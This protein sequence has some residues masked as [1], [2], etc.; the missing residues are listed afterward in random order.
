MMDGLPDYAGFAVHRLAARPPIR[1]I[2]G[3]D[4]FGAGHRILS[5]CYAAERA[6][7]MVNTAATPAAGSRAAGAIDDLIAAISACFSRV[8][9]RPRQF[10]RLLLVVYGASVLIS[11]YRG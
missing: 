7:R 8:L 9:I 6:D 3:G 2:F 4:D 10:R 1:V 11:I 5:S